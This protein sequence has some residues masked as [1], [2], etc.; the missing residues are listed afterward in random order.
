MSGVGS[1]NAY[2][3]N[4]NTPT[5]GYALDAS[6]RDGIDNPRPVGLLVHAFPFALPGNSIA[7]TS[8]SGFAATSG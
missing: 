1:T 4:G 6:P 7:Y 8:S 2:R 3:L 5:N